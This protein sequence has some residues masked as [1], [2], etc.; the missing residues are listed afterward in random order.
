MK[1]ITF[2]IKNYRS[3][4]KAYKLPLHDK[5]ILIG[6]NNEGKSNIL[7]GL[8]LS[9]DT[10]HQGVSRLY[11]MSL[12]ERNIRDRYRA[13]R[14]SNQNLVNYNWERDFPVPLQKTLPGGFSEFI[15]EFE[16]TKLDRDDFLRKTETHLSSNLVLKLNYAQDSTL[17][18]DVV[19]PGPAKKTLKKKYDIISN[20]MRDH[21]N[22]QYIPA[23]RPTEYAVQIVENLLSQELALL[24]DQ[25][26]YKELLH[27]IVIMQNPILVDLAKHLRDSVSEFI[28]DVKKIE[29]NTSENL[30]SA[31]R[32]TCRV[33]ID[34]GIKT[35]LEQKGDGI[36]SLVAISLVR[37]ISK[38]S[39]K[40]RNLIL[41]IEEP[42][43]HLHPAAIQRLSSVLNEISTQQQ[44]IITTH[45]PLLVDRTKI[46]NNILVNKSKALAAKNIA[47]IRD[48]LGVQVS[49]NLTSANW[50]LLV[51]GE[52]DKRI[53]KTWLAE[54]SPKLKKAFDANQIIIDD[55]Q[56]G[57]NLSYKLSQYKNMMCNTF[58]YL[59]NDSCA[60]QSYERAKSQGLINL[61]SIV[62]ST[63]PGRACSEIEDLIAPDTYIES[64]QNNF[65]VVLKGNL[66]KNN[67]KV[68]S[69]RVEDVF[70]NQG[71]IWNKKIE[72]EV[73][74]IVAE[75]V[76]QIGLDSLNPKCRSSIDSLIESLCK[77]MN[78]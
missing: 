7:Q 17:T 66:F 69:D 23:V 74:N 14:L 49:D 16:L 24:E 2:S 4:T 51:E 64:I 18:F 43:S 27:K 33:L 78:L 62:F 50:V 29:L 36:K 73:K 31:I 65:G 76:E 58:S 60:L 44:V 77:K 3:I 61:D 21:L 57:T 53:M 6:P 26:A 8:V 70:L 25:P 56:G 11:K 55:L 35:D 15:L 46:N 75:R 22:F 71:K 13:D 12:M 68:W 1:L 59:D 48:I 10:L 28:P 63:C 67:K 47:Q 9:L 32:H 20:F 37:H 30:R 39:S 40:H 5:S 52:E 54:S 42:E 19:I 34:D 38:K 41:A 45:S 72:N